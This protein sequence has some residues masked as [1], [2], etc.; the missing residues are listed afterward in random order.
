M[1]LGTVDSL[2]A[3]FKSLD[4]GES[5]V[6]WGGVWGSSDALDLGQREGRRKGTVLKSSGVAHPWWPASHSQVPGTEGRCVILLALRWEWV[7]GRASELGAT[8]TCTPR[9]TEGL[10]CAK[11]RV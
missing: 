3:L 4:C 11:H 6:G 7:G 1:G 10:C 8:R 2:E 5:G 9:S